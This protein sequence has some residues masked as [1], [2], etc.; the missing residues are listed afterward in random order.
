[1]LFLTMQFFLS[2]TVW[3]SQN[4][5][6]GMIRGFRKIGGIFLK[7]FCSELPPSRLSVVPGVT[8][9]CQGDHLDFFSETIGRFPGIDDP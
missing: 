7:F 2:T 6:L 8:D 1:M 9:V 3:I 4:S 5:D